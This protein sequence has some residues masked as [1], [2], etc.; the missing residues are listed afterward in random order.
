MGKITLP[1]DVTT[2]G[3]NN[4]DNNNNVEEQQITTESILVSGVSSSFLMPNEE[5]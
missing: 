3:N 1:L 5:L 4:N 2:D